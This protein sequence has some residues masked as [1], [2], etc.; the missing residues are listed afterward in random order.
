MI[1]KILKISFLYIGTV[2]GAG[3]STGKELTTYFNNVNFVTLIFGGIAL[4]LFSGYYLYLGKT[5]E[6]KLS[7][8]AFGKYNKIFDLLVFCSVFFVFVSMFDTADIILYDMFSIKYGGYFT[9][10]VTFLCAI[11][12]ISFVKKINALVIPMV[13]IMVILIYSKEPT[14]TVNGN[15]SIL[16]PIL[17]AGMNIM[18]AG[19]IIKPEGKDLTNKQIASITVVTSVIFAVIMVL[20]YEIV[21]GS[22]DV[23]PL[24]TIAKKYNMHIVAGFV[25][26]IAIVTTALSSETILI[27]YLNLLIPN[28]YLLSL[29]LFL[30]AIP[31]KIYVGFADI[32]AF[33]YPIVSI[34]G[35][36]VTIFSIFS[37]IRYK[38]NKNKIKN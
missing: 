38:I 7:Q 24:F 30:I 16:S 17:Y 11:I 22:V 4:G 5:F 34:L 26:Y 10:V 27:D 36:L 21:N 12:G 3:F 18:L 2:I 35:I 19:Y 25:I 1:Q 31:I 29:V 9:I 23:M 14:I 32:V 37:L 13:I 20:L 6:V 33:V 15:T 28:K 8:I